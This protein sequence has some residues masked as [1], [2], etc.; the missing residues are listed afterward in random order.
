MANNK[1]DNVRFTAEEMA[2]DSAD[3]TDPK[4]WVSVGR[5]PAAI[6]AK[7]RDR[8]KT[9]SPSK[10]SVRFVK[11]TPEEMAYDPSP[12]E[13]ANWT[14]VGRGLASLFAKPAARTVV[15]E[16]DMAKVFKNS[17][18]VNKALRKMIATMPAPRKRKTA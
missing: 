7:L 3:T 10:A 13:T 16:K 17:A 1:H 5:G 8:K 15:L 12:E 6:F 4:R 9:V 14:P 11:F 2:Y 18:S